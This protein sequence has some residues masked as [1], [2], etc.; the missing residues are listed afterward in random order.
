MSNEPFNPDRACDLVETVL[1]LP[2][3]EHIGAN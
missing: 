2:G 1:G 3:Y